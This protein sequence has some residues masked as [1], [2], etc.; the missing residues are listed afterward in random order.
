M[1]ARDK[2][3]LGKGEVRSMLKECANCEKFNKDK[4]ECYVMKELIAECW[5]WTKDKEWQQKVEKEVKQYRESKE[6]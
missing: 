3:I 1:G 2:D 5:A 4:K 6:G